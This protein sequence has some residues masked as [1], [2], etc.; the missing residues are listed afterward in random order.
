MESYI[1]QLLDLIKQPDSSLYTESENE[2]N[3]KQNKSFV[4]KYNN[5]STE[6]LLSNY[7][8]HLKSK[9]LLNLIS[10]YHL[11]EAMCKR[12]I[13]VIRLIYLS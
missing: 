12:V 4:K 9:E 8:A 3:N 11:L 5:L 6:I 1:S 10:M 2:V 13:L 7:R